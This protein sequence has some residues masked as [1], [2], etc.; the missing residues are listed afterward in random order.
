MRT[1]FR[2]SVFGALLA[3]SH[4]LQITYTS[5]AGAAFGAARTL[6][7]L[8]S[9]DGVILLNAAAPVSPLLRFPTP[10]EPR[11]PSEFQLNL[12]RVVDTLRTSYPSLLRA[13]QDYS[14]FAPEVTFQGLGL[15]LTGLD[16]YQKMWTAVRQA[17][18]V[19]CSDSELTYRLIVSGRTV[20]VRW[21]AKLWLKDPT[22]ALRKMTSG[23]AGNGA[24]SAQVDGVSVYEL[25][26]EA[27][28]TS[29]R[30]EHVVVNDDH[31]EARLT[32]ETAWRLPA[33]AR[34][35]GVL[36]GQR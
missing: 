31:A 36:A 12:G 27:F 19:A 5:T 22:R 9:T 23:E 26:D 1:A 13:P 11:G 14:I 8:T 32:L 7:P 20:R 29:H 6:A 21:S 18:G 24:A 34:P 28:I 33:L 4:A 16:N 2:T 30:L 35:E 3:V 15:N 10:P 25:D 17:H